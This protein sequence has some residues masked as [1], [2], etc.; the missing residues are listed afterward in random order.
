MI[1]VQA[2]QRSENGKCMGGELNNL[3]W[4]LKDTY[5]ILN[6]NYK[7]NFLFNLDRFNRAFGCIV[8]LIYLLYFN[9][10]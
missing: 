8:I 9:I 10:L 4:D 1:I 2:V 3:T 7:S 6:W 5:N